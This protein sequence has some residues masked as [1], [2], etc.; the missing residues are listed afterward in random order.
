MPDEA[1]HELE[2]AAE[3]RDSQRLQEAIWTA[4]KYGADQGLIDIMETIREE[5]S[6]FAISVAR[7]CC[8]L[9]VQQTC[10]TIEP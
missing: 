3:S 7:S 1:F 6:D 4:Q 8:S 10:R 5:V 9:H 2:L